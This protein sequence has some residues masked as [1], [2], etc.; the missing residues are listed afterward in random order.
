MQTALLSAADADGETVRTRNDTRTTFHCLAVKIGVINGSKGEGC[1]ASL[2]PLHNASRGCHGDVIR[3]LLSA[4]LS[5]L[6]TN[7]E[8]MVRGHNNRLSPV[9]DTP[10]RTIHS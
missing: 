6:Q 5:P 7:L 4:G 2:Q 8:G 10:I 1:V 3:V 9:F